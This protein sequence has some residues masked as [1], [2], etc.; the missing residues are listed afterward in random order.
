MTR[1]QATLDLVTLFTRITPLVILRCHFVNVLT[2]E[3]ASASAPLLEGVC[4][5]TDPLDEVDGVLVCF[6]L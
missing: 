4:V 1:S 6:D 3:D 5:Q 2:T